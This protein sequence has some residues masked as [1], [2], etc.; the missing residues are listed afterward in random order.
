MGEMILRNFLT[1]LAVISLWGCSQ[2]LVPGKYQSYSD[3]GI[4]MAGKTITIIDEERFEYQYWSDDISSNRIGQGTYSISGN[5]IDFD[6]KDIKPLANVI[7]IT[8]T[9]DGAEK[10]TIT[11]N[12]SD[13]NGRPL[14]GVLI[15]VSD[16]NYQPLI[17]DLTKI[18]GKYSFEIRPYDLPLT[19]ETDYLGMQPAEIRI[20]D[21]RSKYLNI[22]LAELTNYIE[23]GT[24]YRFR[25]KVG[26]DILTLKND[27]KQVDK[28]KR[29]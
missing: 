10:Q 3:S 25:F 8:E 18:G 2:K 1:G 17:Q 22:R 16:K 9:I 12:V 20:S 27:N 7:E 26:K 28:L 21:S 19:I 15:Q 29:Q 23:K 4:L 14:V 5:E 11:M 24:S 6:F 13:Q